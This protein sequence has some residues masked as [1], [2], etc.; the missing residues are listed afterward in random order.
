MYFNKNLVS[1]KG[2]WCVTWTKQL[3]VHTNLFKLDCLTKFLQLILTTFNTPFLMKYF[4]TTAW[5][6]RPVGPF[7]LLRTGQWS[8]QVPF[9]T[10]LVDY[11]AIDQTHNLP[12]EAGALALTYLGGY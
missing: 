9:Y 1:C 12:L 10:S 2:T 3:L 7:L 5:Q 4:T 6:M 8:L 11:E